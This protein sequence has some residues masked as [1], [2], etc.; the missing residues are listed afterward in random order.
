MTQWYLGIQTLFFFSC[1][2]SPSGLI[3]MEIMT[4]DPDDPSK[5]AVWDAAL[6]WR[7]LMWRHLH[8]SATLSRPNN[9]KYS[10]TV[11]VSFVRCV[12]QFPPG[13][14]YR[15]SRV[16]NDSVNLCNVDSKVCLY[17]KN[18]VFLNQTYWKLLS[19]N[20]GISRSHDEFT[21]CLTSG[22]MLLHW[23]VTWWLH[24]GYRGDMSLLMKRQAEPG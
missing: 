20:I 16:T 10:N 6:S 7:L 8:G 1:F 24:D 5:T 19:F 11:K 17:I 9:I 14:I 21:I 2:F 4:F 23:T 18:R 3:H 22:C 12:L 15:V 13:Q